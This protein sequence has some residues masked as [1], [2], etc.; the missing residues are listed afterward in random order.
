MP[1]AL[2]A[3]KPNGV[4]DLQPHEDSQS[5]PAEAT[6]ATAGQMTFAA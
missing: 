2:I 4:T 3:K 6:G 5:A 1:S